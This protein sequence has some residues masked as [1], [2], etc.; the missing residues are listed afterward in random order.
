MNEI[1]LLTPLMRNETEINKDFL[2]SMQRGP[3][4]RQYRAASNYLRQAKVLLI[5]MNNILLESRRAELLLEAIHHLCEA[6]DYSMCLA[7]LSEVV[8]EKTNLSLYSHL[9]YRG[10]AKR[11]LDLTEVLLS[12]FQAVDHSQYFLKILKAK[13][14]ESLGQRSEAIQIYEKICTE[15]PST[16]LEYVEAFSRLAGCQIQMGSYDIGIPNVENALKRLEKLDFRRVDIEA[17]LIENM[18]FY[19]MNSGNLDEASRLFKSVFEMR[20]QECIVTALVNPLGHQGI[21][22]R[23]RAAS[24]KYLIS[25]LGTNFLRLLRLNYIARLFFDKFCEPLIPELND[26]YSKAESLFNQAYALSDTIGDENV[27]SWISHHLAWVLIN[28]GQAVLAKNY[29]L[30]ALEMYEKIGDRRGL[31]DCHEQLG[32]IYLAI[33]N[34]NTDAARHHFSQSLNIR[35]EIGNFHGAASS[36]LNFSFLYWHMGNYFKSVRFL[37]QGM[38]KYY[39]V[40]LL[41]PK[42]I[43]LITILFSVWTVGKRDWTL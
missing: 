16:S 5:A 26:N 31:S 19:R 22:S 25:L 21:V 11:L 39:D 20:E 10:K 8:D 36:V 12:R 1:S 30:Q 37:L 43:L 40:G 29:A 23:K 41:N 7:T 13:S 35:N 2:Y 33:D 28:K 4:R 42:R 14:F 17:D 32:R 24:Q 6:Q 27:K 18:A 15:E 9:L 38:K 34:R 3:K